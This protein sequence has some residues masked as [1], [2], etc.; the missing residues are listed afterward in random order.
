MERGEN[1]RTCGGFS[2]LGS[3]IGDLAAP[4]TEGYVDFHPLDPPPCRSAVRLPCCASIPSL[5]P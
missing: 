3:D 4:G 1:S 2:G 5:S